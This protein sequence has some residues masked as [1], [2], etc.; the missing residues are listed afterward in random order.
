MALDNDAPNSSILS[1]PL[2]LLK[3]LGQVLPCRVGENEHGS[4]RRQRHTPLVVW[5]CS[6]TLGDAAPSVCDLGFEGGS[7]ASALE[8]PPGSMVLS[9]SLLASAILFKGPSAPFGT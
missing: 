7:T 4:R 5:A 9:R 3:A 2:E 8:S 6:S 1:W